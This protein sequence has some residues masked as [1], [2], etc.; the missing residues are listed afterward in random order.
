[1][2]VGDGNSSH[3]HV[4]DLQ[5]AIDLIPPAGGKICLLPGRHVAAA[6]LVA[7]TNIMIEGCGPR[8]RVVSDAGQS[9]PVFEIEAGADITL[10]DFAIE[11]VETIAVRAVRTDRLTLERLD[12]GVAGRAAVIASAIDGFDLL[13]SIIT[14]LEQQRTGTAPTQEPAVFAS[15][16][17]LQILRNRIAAPAVR[18]ARL[19]ATGGLQIGGDSV[20][21]LIED[22][23]IQGGTGAGIVLGSVDFQL[24]PTIVNVDRLRAHYVSRVARPG[25]TNL[26]IVSDDD[27]L[28][29]DPHPVPP[30]DPNDPS[31]PEP[32]SD[33]PVEDCRIIDNRII[34][35]G[36][37]G[38]TAAYWFIPDREPDGIVTNR[39]LIAENLIDRC[40]RLPVGI[41]QP[42]LL[43]IAGFGGIALAIGAEIAIRDNRI[44]N[45]GTEH[46]A[47]IVGIYVLDGVAVAIQRNHLRDNGRV[48]DLENA[49]SAGRVGAIVLGLVRPGTDL[50]TP[51]NQVVARQDGAPALIVEDNVAVAREG[52][53]L[54]AVGVGPMVIHGNQ[55]T[56]HGTNSLRRVLVPGVAANT[57]GVSGLALIGLAGARPPGIR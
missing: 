22:N 32:V 16:R 48:A 28:T 8:T 43:E 26:V 33:G 39:L 45:V 40:M 20:D 46:A 50:V 11:A 24:R 10:R 37:S 18:R 9:A 57:V 55:F 54:L 44:T 31:P 3:G 25:F 5:A 29:L 14:Q 15:G 1:M 23:L 4:D 52:R 36:G 12:I 2:H 56:A 6:R 13:D 30:P 42:E 35:M 17:A 19:S 47:P 41:I 7:R 49:I 53:A 51:I 38:I 34:G 27:C 21:V